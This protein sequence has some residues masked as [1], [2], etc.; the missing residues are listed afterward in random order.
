M[1]ECVRTYAR[2]AGPVGSNDTSELPMDE[3][4]SEAAARVQAERATVD[5]VPAEQI[6]GERAHVKSTNLKAEDTVLV[7]NDSS[8][9]LQTQEDKSNVTE[10][11]SREAVEEMDISKEGTTTNKQSQEGAEGKSEA[12]DPSSPNE[13]PA[14]AAPLRRPI[15]RRRPNIPQDRKPTATMIPP[16]SPPVM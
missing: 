16:L 12:T 7:K 1:S 15:V 5:S 2:V 10:E 4:D 8:E 9:A 13:H 11:V 3:A 14:K 6:S